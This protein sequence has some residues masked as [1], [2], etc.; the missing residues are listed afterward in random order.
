MPEREAALGQLALEVGPEHA[1]LHA[2]EARDRVDVEHAREPRE[3][4]RDHRAR[5]AGRRLEAAGDAGAAAERDQ[6][7]VGVE[8]RAHDRLHR[9]LVGRAHDGVGQPPELAAALAHE[10]AQALAAPVH[11]AVAGVGRDVGGALE[12]RAQ[13]AGQIRLGDVERLERRAARCPGA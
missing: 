12:R 13:L 11:D 6:H 5:L 7:R 8:H 2:R 3:V 1:R 4:E 9:R 10:V